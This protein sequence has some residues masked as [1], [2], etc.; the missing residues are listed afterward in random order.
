MLKM[1]YRDLLPI[2]S[3]LHRRTDF[4]KLF[5]MA[6]AFRAGGG[7]EIWMVFPVASLQVSRQVVEISIRV[8]R[9]H[10]ECE[11][12][13]TRV[14]PVGSLQHRLV[15]RNYIARVALQC[16]RRYVA[17]GNAERRIAAVDLVAKRLTGLVHDMAAGDQTQRAGI[18]AYRIQV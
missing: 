16:Q 5:K 7:D 9:A 12:S 18:P 4:Q 15:K 6:T 14:A 8:T 2:P 11:H 13:Q 17:S 3:F 1:I 10:I